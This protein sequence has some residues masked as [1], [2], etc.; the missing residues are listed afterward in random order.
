M[1]KKIRMK[2]KSSAQLT[3]EVQEILNQEIPDPSGGI[4]SFIGKP[5]TI[6]GKPAK[7]YNKGRKRRDT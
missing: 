2:T 5:H 4:A 6:L 1:G 7:E 3:K